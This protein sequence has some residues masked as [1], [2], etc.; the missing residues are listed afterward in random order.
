M[1]SFCIKTLGCKVNAY[2]SEYIHSLFEQKGFLYTEENAD[3]YIIN[4]CTV[5]NM[6]DRKSRQIIN[7][8]KKKYPN[9]IT[10]VCG[11]YAQNCY[12]T[13]KLEDIKADIIIGNKDKS[14]IIEYLEE[15]I[16]N[17]TK[18]EQFYD[19]KH[20]EFENME[21]QKK[22]NRTR[23][24]VKIEDGCNNFCTYCIIPYIR[25][26][27][28]SKDFNKIKEEVTYLVQNGHKEIVLT[29]IHTGAYNDGTHDFADLIKELV[30]VPNLERLRISSIEI[31]E[32]NEKVLEVFKNSSILV[33]HLHI[34][35]QSGSEQILRL[36]NRK[37][38]KEKYEEKINQI[39]QTKENISITTDVIVGFP[40]E[41][42]EMHKESLEFIKKIGFTKVHVFPYS[43]RDGTVASKMENK[44]DGN[45]KKRRV[46]ELLE[47][48]EKLEE[49]YYKKYNGQTMEVLIEEKK[50]NSFIGH[51]S[52]FIKVKIEGNYVTNQIYN[53]KLTKDNI[54]KSQ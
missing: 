52:N 50:E 4:T 43:D 36:M 30:K 34:P 1:M 10:I 11:C 28:R 5:T 19:L 16:E 35:L 20:V 47:L 26:G 13:G 8:I 21:I 54:I 38:T 44:I 48:S 53:I 18:I 42:E 6:S 32:L 27:V 3:I 22:E 31:N 7:S 40:N 14:K 12:Q 33:P 45:I 51:T 46:R 29:G 37:Y 25:G 41:T 15:Y 39:K 2:E 17:K 9:S 49:E 23:A 24:Y